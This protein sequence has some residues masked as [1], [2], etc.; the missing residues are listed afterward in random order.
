[1]S[2]GR[3]FVPPATL[4]DPE[5]IMLPPEVAAQVRTV[6][7]L[8]PGDT[9]TLLDGMGTAYTVR[10]I[11]VEREHVIGCVTASDGVTTEPYHRVI[12]YQG[13]LKAAKF[14][15]IVQKGTEL[16][17]AG[18]VPVHCARSVVEDV[19]VTKLQRWRTIATEAAE[20]SERGCI[21]VIESPVTFAAA[22]ASLERDPEVGQCALLAWE[23]IT[24]SPDAATITT[25]L[26]PAAVATIALFIGPEG[27]F[28][29]EEVTRASECGVRLVTLGKRI[30]RAETAAIAAITLALS[31][32]GEMGR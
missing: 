17:V 28:T 16:G 30:L 29:A 1:M 6:L 19:S 7:R 27:G 32:L 26:R 31:A 23:G 9:V 4:R 25:L 3:F 8:R 2:A 20:Q 22:L 18:I 24:T 14:E 11:A 5:R 12:L 15:W 13:L 21:P 10:L